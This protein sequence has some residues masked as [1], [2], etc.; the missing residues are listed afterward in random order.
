M[1]VHIHS[2][3]P[4]PLLLPI[5]PLHPVTSSHTPHL[6]RRFTSWRP[7]ALCIMYGHPADPNQVGMYVV[8]SCH[9]HAIRCPPAPVGPSHIRTQWCRPACTP[10][11][12]FIHSCPS[13]CFSPSTLFTLS[14]RH[15]HHT[16]H[17]GSRRGR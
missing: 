13:P 8:Y 16:C 14:H 10:Q 17:A 7:I 2:L 9:M 6:S 5:H 11:Y 1:C 4:L 12:T 3:L 15:T